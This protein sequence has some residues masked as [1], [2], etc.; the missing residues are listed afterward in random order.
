MKNTGRFR[1]RLIAAVA[2]MATVV[3]CALG[4]P[5]TSWAKPGK[6][7]CKVLLADQGN[8][9]HPIKGAVI[10]VVGMPM[11]ASTNENGTLSFDSVEVGA[12]YMV[13]ATYPGYKAAI[14]RHVEVHSG[15]TTDLEFVIKEP[16][17][18]LSSPSLG[19]KLPSEH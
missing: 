1:C 15:K 18:I 14:E 16:E 9:P 6:M 10:K 12:D 5:G 13:V 17:V 11:K 2:V 4:T 19:A 3:V 8:A 7:V